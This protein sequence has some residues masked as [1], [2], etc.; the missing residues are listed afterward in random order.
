MH[1]DWEFVQKKEGGERGGAGGRKEKKIKKIKK[2]ERE[3]E[4]NK[5]TNKAIKKTWAFYNGGEEVS[6]EIIGA[7][8]VVGRHAVS[9]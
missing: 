4:G 5:E 7:R 8:V 3:R 9:I 2:R 6:E 1:S